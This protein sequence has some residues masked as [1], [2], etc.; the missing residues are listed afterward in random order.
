MLKIQG[1]YIA[2]V[3]CCFLSACRT[4]QTEYKYPEK[5]NGRYE[6]PSEKTEK[7]TV[8]DK[9][10]LTF[11]F[12]GEKKENASGLSAKKTE[13]LN[14]EESRPL[15]PAVLPVLSRYPIALV[16]KDELVMTEW[17]SD[18]ENPRR[19][20][21]INAVKT[22]ADV[23]ITVLCRQKDDNGGWI[24]QKNDA[25]LADKIKNDIV[26]QSFNY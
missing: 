2:A 19:Q 23:Q 11:T 3:L 12:G 1:K 7:D 24:N 26:K 9:K 13:N 21:K 18:P 25:A 22:G 14:R 4:G 16:Q 10:Y 5:V 15:W 17:F 20:L 8:F 6:M